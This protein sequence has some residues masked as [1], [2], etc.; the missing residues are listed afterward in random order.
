[1]RAGRVFSIGILV[2][3]GCVA[4]F[5][6]VIL[7]R[8]NM[9]SAEAA[10]LVRVVAERPK[11]PD[12]DNGY[13]YVWGFIA[14]PSDDAERAAAERVAWL[15]EKS[16][17]PGNSSVDPLADDS[18]VAQRRSRGLQQLITLCQDA[19][20]PECAARFDGW[21][22]APTSG[23]WET[24]KLA[25]YH[26]LRTHSGWFESITFVA[27][28]P[29]PPFGDVFDAQKL[30]FLRLRE[31]ANAGKTD[32]LRAALDAD[33]EFWRV[34][35]RDADILITK[36]IAL[37]GVRQHFFFGNLVLR[38]LPAEGAA[39]AIPASWS[40]P[41]TPQELSMLRVLAGEL[42]FVRNEIHR[43]YNDETIYDDDGEIMEG[44]EATVR[45]WMV[46]IQWGIQPPQRAINRIAE[47]YLVTAQAFAVPLDQYAR[48]EADIKARFPP[49][50]ETPD[51]TSYSFRA[52]TAEAMRRAALLTAQLR[53]RGVPAEQVPDEVRR[54]A[55]R[56]PFTDAPFAWDATQ[57]VLKYESADPRRTKTQWYFY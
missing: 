48:A 28:N 23:E 44:P 11:V 3:A 36:M 22:A 6:L 57:R 17:D 34:M 24:A 12:A 16:H 54:A 27:E 18:E 50:T 37:A 32:E 53:G 35:F 14:A 30:E 13:L 7:W 33:L 29:F 31:L 52:G 55:L 51:A 40:R 19:Q 1:M 20:W 47:V 8:W 2:V 45:R 4:A 46:G 5:A 15:R 56:N 42:A 21:E 39:A 49:S 25:R 43:Q 9:P 26:S 41:F 38:R 10:T